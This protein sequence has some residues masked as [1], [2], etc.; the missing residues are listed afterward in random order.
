MPIPSRRIE[1]V[2]PPV[3]SPSYFKKSGKTTRESFNSTSTHSVISR[4]NG[5]RSKFNRVFTFLCLDSTDIAPTASIPGL[6]C[7]VLA[8]VVDFVVNILQ[9]ELRLEVSAKKSKVVG[10]SLKL[11][12]ACASRR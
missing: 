12:H 9:G 6:S 3:L 8:A 4:R 2:L 10:S 5:D 7:C 11:A 1:K